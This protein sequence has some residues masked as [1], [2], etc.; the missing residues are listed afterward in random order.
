MKNCHLCVLT[1]I[2][3]VFAACHKKPFGVKGKGSSVSETRSVSDFQK[4]KLSVDAELNFKMDSIYYLEINAQQNVLDEIET[5]V[6]GGDLVIKT[7]TFFYKHNPI[8]ITVHAPSVNSLSVS[9]S[10]KI[11]CADSLLNSNLKLEISG[12]GRIDA[13]KIK[14][15]GL[16]VHISGSGEVNINSGTVSSL[17][18][19]ISGSGKLNSEYLLAENAKVSVSG[20][21]N[22]TLQASQQLNVSISGSGTVRYRG[23]PQVNSNISDS[24]KLIHI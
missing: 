20:S 13:S 18:Y 11:V 22:V 23:N 14:A 2:V 17:V 9:G 7:E 6:S 10:G 19:T 21:G 5:D 3:I 1:L 12:S 8:K 24:G 15:T 4:I 16:E